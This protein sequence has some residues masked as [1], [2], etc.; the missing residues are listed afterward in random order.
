MKKYQSVI[1]GHLDIFV[2][3]NEDEFQ[4][5]KLE[6]QEVLIHGDP[7]GLRS[8]GELLIKMA[9]L[10]QNDV[11]DLPTGAREHIHLQSDHDLSKISVAVIVGRIDAKG[12]G[13]FYDRYVARKDV[14][15]ESAD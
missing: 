7:D 8:L 14:E 3:D 15:N 6:W 9:G 5:E 13:D 10:N 11:T 1:K 2:A 4:G 12:T